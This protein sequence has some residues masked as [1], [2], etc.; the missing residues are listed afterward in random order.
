MVLLGWPW[1]QEDRKAK[2][3]GYGL[4]CEHTAGRCCLP[5]I[6][7]RSR[8]WVEAGEEVEARDVEKERDQRV[9]W[10]GTV[11]CVHLPGHFGTCSGGFDVVADDV[12]IEPEAGSGSL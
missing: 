7:D 10:L 11:A 2:V 6:A 4:D 5:R 1:L 8:D 3:V 9:N 12:G